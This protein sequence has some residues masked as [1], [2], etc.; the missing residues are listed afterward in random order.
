M[1]TIK[2][3]DVLK[4]RTFVMPNMWGYTVISTNEYVSPIRGEHMYV[5][6][7]KP[8]PN[9]KEV[10]FTLYRDMNKKDGGYR[11]YNTISGDY[12]IVTKKGL[13]DMRAFTDILKKE[14]NSIC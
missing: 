9:Y 8:S 1:L 10:S 13:K 3:F 14:L 4:G 2:N 5:L 12:I 6:K 7:L 11:L